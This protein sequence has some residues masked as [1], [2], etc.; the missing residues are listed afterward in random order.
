MEPKLAVEIVAKVGVSEDGFVEI[1]TDCD[2]GSRGS[3]SLY[4]PCRVDDAL[5]ILAALE[6]KRA[7]LQRVAAKLREDD[8]DNTGHTVVLTSG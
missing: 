6:G 8:P 2:Y 4:L 3:Y 7:E 5:A 1:S